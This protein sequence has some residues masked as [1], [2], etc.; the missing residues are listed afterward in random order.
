MGARDALQRLFCMAAGNPVALLIVPYSLPPHSTVS[1]HHS[2]CQYFR[3]Y[4]RQS[5]GMFVSHE[6][7][8]FVNRAVIH[9][10][11]S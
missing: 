8:G 1:G 11:S 3:N 5:H 4:T 10:L 2:V 6:A 9:H 7:S